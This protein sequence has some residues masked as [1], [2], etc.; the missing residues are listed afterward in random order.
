MSNDDEQTTLGVANGRSDEDSETADGA[1][2]HCGI[3]VPENGR[4][5]GPCL[6]ELRAADREEP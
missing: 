6:D 2:V 3:V 5:C 1:C 4:I